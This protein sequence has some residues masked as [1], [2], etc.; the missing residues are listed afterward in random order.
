MIMVTG[1]SL[2]MFR[3][4]TF[5]L[6]ITYTQSESLLVSYL[7]IKLIARKLN[8]YKTWLAN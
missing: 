6:V 5:N 1:G 3:Y 7:V 2:T 8:W 4:L